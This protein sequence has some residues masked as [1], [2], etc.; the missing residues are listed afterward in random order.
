VTK[1]VIAQTILQNALLTE[2]GSYTLPNNSPVRAIYVI[3]DPKKDPPK[4]WKVTGVECRIQK[5]ADRAGQRCFNG[6]QDHYIW[7]C[8]LIQYDRSKSLNEAIDAL[9]ATKIFGLSIGKV[10]P[11]SED[12]FE[13]VSFSIVT[14]QYFT[15]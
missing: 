3:G 8:I 6:D 2:L 13:Q 14:H 4:D 1:P 7:Q 11:Q 10:I 5:T 9:K 15:Y 12:N